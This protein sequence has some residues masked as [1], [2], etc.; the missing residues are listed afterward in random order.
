MQRVRAAPAVCAYLPAP[1]DAQLPPGCPREDTELTLIDPT[2]P[3]R[4]CSDYVVSV[5]TTP[6]EYALRHE[7]RRLRWRV[8]ARAWAAL[9]PEERDRVA[10]KLRAAQAE[11][12]RFDREA[13]DA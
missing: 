9:R 11:A 12:L 5:V 13:P 8:E 6:A 3:E 1:G 2:D 10:E 4:Y 7:L